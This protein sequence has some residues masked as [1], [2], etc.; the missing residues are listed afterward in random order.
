MAQTFQSTL[1]RRERPSRLILSTLL[2]KFQ[3]TLPRRERPKR[4]EANAMSKAIS[5]HAPAKGATLNHHGDCAVHRYFNPR[6]REGSDPIQP[7]TTLLRNGISI[8]APAKG[9]TLQILHIC[10]APEN[11]NPRSREGSDPLYC[12]CSGCERVDFNPRSREGSDPQAHS[13]CLPHPAISIHAPAKGATQQYFTNP[14]IYIV[15]H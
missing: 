15:K 3:S 7:L 12:F 1:P 13:R 2:S 14:Q 11:F 9:A 5:I 6:S 8:H 10:T 4:R